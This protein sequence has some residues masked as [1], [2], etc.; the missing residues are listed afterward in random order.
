MLQSMGSQRTGQ[1]NNNNSKTGEEGKRR[2]E[3]GLKK[4]KHRLWTLS[5]LNI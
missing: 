5:R 3:Y 2:A 4:I 1:L